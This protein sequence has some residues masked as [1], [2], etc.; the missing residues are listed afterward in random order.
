MRL[1]QRPGARSRSLLVWGGIGADTVP[2]LAPAFVVEAPP[3]LPDS[4]GAYEVTGRTA[5][6]G[7]LFT[8]SFGM[9]EKVDGD[10]S[11]SFA[12]VLPVRPGWEALASITLT[13]PSGS[14]TLDGE[15]NIPVAIL[16]DP[17]TGQVRGILRDPPPAPQAAA[18]AAG[19]GVGAGLGVLF[20]RGI[21]DAAAWRR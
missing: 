17:R 16:R 15:S 21:P 19:Q 4:A 1:H 3:A 7:A 2:Y 5:D 14:V 11:S 10:S 13:G 8:L 12:F 20:S 6:G 18:D 9:P